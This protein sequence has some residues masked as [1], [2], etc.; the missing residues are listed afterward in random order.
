MLRRIISTVLG[1]RGA[2]AVGDACPDGTCAGQADDAAMV[3]IASTGMKYPAVPKTSSFVQNSKSVMSSEGGLL[4]GGEE[5]MIKINK[6]GVDNTYSLLGATTVDG[7]E[8]SCLKLIHIPKTGGS[9]IEEAGPRSK[10]HWGKYDSTLKCKGEHT[11]CQGCSFWHLPPSWNTSL[12]DSYRSCDTFCVVR[13]PMSRVVSEYRFKLNIA[14]QQDKCS[15][16][17]FQAWLQSNL[18]QKDRRHDD[19][20][21]VPQ[22]DYVFSKEGART[23]THVLRYENIEKE[24]SALMGAWG[25]NV[26]LQ[27]H[28]KLYHNCHISLPE[29]SR[30]EIREFFAEDF[31]TFGYDP[32]G[33]PDAPQSR[34][35]A[36]L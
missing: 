4:G 21:W 9:S 22:K 33:E 26:P 8:T 11:G 7:G 32:H 1:L 6:D 29:S 13:N 3:Q 35:V 15:S 27:L 14:R 24:F 16:E 17:H 5:G 10:H 28:K 12:W 25:F 20:H 31:A 18:K 19:C 30:A 23:C 34:P 36:V 2:V